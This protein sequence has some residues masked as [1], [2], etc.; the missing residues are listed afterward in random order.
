MLVTS[1]IAGT[2]V[3]ADGDAANTAETQAQPQ[4][5]ARTVDKT[6]KSSDAAAQDDGSVVYSVDVPVAVADGEPAGSVTVDVTAPAGALPDGVSLEAAPVSDLDAVAS[7]LADADVDYAGF[8]ALDVRFAGANDDEVE[9][10]APVDVRFETPQSVLGDDV[11]ASTLAVRHFVENEQGEVEKV[12][13]VADAVDAMETD[14]DAQ[15]DSSEGTVSV[16]GG[17]ESSD[18]TVA[19]EFT[20]DGFSAFAITYGKSVASEKSVARTVSGVLIDNTIAQNGLLTARLEGN[21]GSGQTVT[22]QWYRSETGTEGPWIEVTRQVVTGSQYNVSEDGSQLNVAYDGVAAGVQDAQRYFYRVEAT[23]KSGSGEPTVLTSQ[24]FQVP[25]YVELQNGSFENPEITHWNNQLPNGTDGL[26]WQ[27]TG[28]GTGEHDNAD[29]E[30]VRSTDER[31]ND[32]GQSK[33]FQQKVQETYSPSSADDGVQF[34]ELNCEEYGALYQDVLTTPGAA[35]NWWLSHRARWDLNEH[36]TSDKMALVIMPTDLAANLTNRLEQIANGGGSSSYKTQ[37]IQNAINGYQGR[38]GVYI[39]YITDDTGDW[40]RYDGTY[41]VGS[42]QYLT[43]FFFVAVSTGSNNPTVGNLLDNVGFGSHVPEPDT[44]EGVIN[45]KKVVDGYIPADGYSVDVTVTGEGVD[46][47]VKLDNFHFDSATGD[48]VASGFVRI[49]NMAPGSS[50]QLTVSETV[51]N[52]PAG[53]QATGSTVAVGEDNAE[54]APSTDF[55]LVAGRTQTVT[56]TNSYSGGGEVTQEATVTTG[57]TAVLRDDGNYDLTLTVSGDRGTSENKQKVDVLFILDKSGSMTSSRMTQLK[58]AVDTLVD[59]VEGNEG[60]EARYAAVA[61]AGDGGGNHGSTYT[62]DTNGDAWR[63]GA[64]IKTF[65]QSI[66][67]GGGTN[68]QRAIHEGK[69]LLNGADDDALTFVVFVS[70]GIPTYRG[71]SNDS[72]SG[73]DDDYGLNIRAAVNEIK[74][75]SCDYFYAIGMGSDFGQNSWWPYEDKQGTKNLKSLA[76]NVNATSKGDGNVYSAS[77][78]QG[79][80]DAFNRI[81]GDITHFAA[82]DVTITDPLS[83]YADLVLTDG[84]LQ[85]TITVKHGEQ[86]WTGT[87]G[88]NGTVTFQDAGGNNKTAKARVSSDNRTIYLDLPDDYELEEGYTYSISTVIAPSQAAKSAGMDSD[89][90]KRTPD[91]HTGTHS[92]TNPKQQGFWSNDNENAK[93]TYTA[94]GEKGSKNFPKPVIQVQEPKEVTI[95]GLV[96]TKTV[97]GKS[98]VAGEFSFTVTTTGDKA[99]AAMSKAEL[100]GIKNEDGTSYTYTF[101]NPEAITLGPN[102][103]EATDVDMRKSHNDGK[104]LTFTE[105]ETGTYTYVY[106]ETTPTGGWHQDAVAFDSNHTDQETRAWKVEIT[107]TNDNGLQATVSVYAASDAEGGSW[108][109]TPVFTHTYTPNSAESELSTPIVIPFVNEYVPPVSALPLTGG[110]ATA[111]NVLLAG[112]GVLLLAGGAWLLARRRRI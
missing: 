67:A 86:T 88:N 37:Q 110:D 17:S 111:R 103:T 90:A 28:E 52:A 62:T 39:Q 55:T 41:T 82:K 1:V 57:K 96:E 112:G 53:Y 19:A 34:A 98:A 58:S 5:T 93:V 92:E 10:T 44:D 94:N 31:F 9:P 76:N 15:P 65:V 27:T 22:Y 12:E 49:E 48:Y 26:V 64:G 47:S 43:R 32:D 89:A 46:E 77:D 61:F 6:V 99:E 2:A 3:A 105:G 30:I 18:A 95:P 78:T 109:T 51:N 83:R 60:I 11:D 79:M 24:S 25:Y 100:D 63:D 91:D 50:K 108:Y 29:I 75:M 36:A 13:T 68:Y 101:G 87:V 4:T 54:N 71:N 85:F 16:N 102:A 14:A 56:F 33:T 59:T 69:M 70:D 80:Q 21:P 106:K 35:L 107:V 81:T 38:G 20:V 66:S 84:A 7:E 8:L 73:N 23:V 97:S 45:I 74:G 72:G 42:N 40:G 104:G